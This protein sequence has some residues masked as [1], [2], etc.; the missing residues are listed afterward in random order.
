VGLVQSQ[1][2]NRNVTDG[3]GVREEDSMP[4]KSRA[5]PTKRKGEVPVQEA[6]DVEREVTRREPEGER[7][8]DVERDEPVH[9]GEP[10][11]H[12]E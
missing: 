4:R 5:K 6:A 12:Q 11:E 9:R 7:G 3:S 2:S 1:G 8:R 10:P